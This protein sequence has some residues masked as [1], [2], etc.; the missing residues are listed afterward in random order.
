MLHKNEK[1]IR[2]RPGTA[3]AAAEKE[4]ILATLRHCKGNKPAAAKALGMSLKTLYNRL[5][6][7]SPKSLKIKK[8]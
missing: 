3:L 5:N 2:I 6:R 1:Q 8:P 4:L 7:Y